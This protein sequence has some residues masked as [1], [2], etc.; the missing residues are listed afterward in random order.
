[1]N[2]HIS[3]GEARNFFSSIQHYLLVR[4]RPPPPPFVPVDCHR[5]GQYTDMKCG[6]CRCCFVCHFISKNEN[7]NTKQ[8]RTDKMQ[9]RKWM[10]VIDLRLQWKK[11]ERNK[12]NGSAMHTASTD[13]GNKYANASDHSSHLCACH[14]IT[15][16]VPAQHENTNALWFHESCSRSFSCQNIQNDGAFLKVSI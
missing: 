16:R 10:G 1:M 3:P 15:H 11:K 4:H 5:A 2:S 7:K 9:N 14:S 13:G 12:W 6:E 8:E